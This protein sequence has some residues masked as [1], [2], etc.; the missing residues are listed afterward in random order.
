LW[1]GDRTLSE[2]PLSDRLGAFVRAEHRLAGRRHVTLRELADYP[3]IL[4]G[5][6]SSVRQL[7]DRVL[8]R[9]KLSM[10]I[11]KNGTAT[12]EL[13]GHLIPDPDVRDVLLLMTHRP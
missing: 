9:E 10:R 12:L 2:Q 8:E 6:V 13:L 11:A 5:K 3:L 1:A 4:T 7:L